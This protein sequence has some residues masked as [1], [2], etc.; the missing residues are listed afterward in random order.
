MPH[1]ASLAV[2]AF[3]GIAATSTP[4]SAQQGCIAPPRLRS[5]HMSLYQTSALGEWY[6]AHKQLQC[7]LDVLRHGAETY[8]EA[9]PIHYAYGLALMGSSGRA[10][11]ALAELQEAVRLDPQFDGAFLALGM[12]AHDHGDRVE[13]LKQWQRAAELNPGSV[14]ALDWIAKARMEAGQYTG[15]MDLLATA[16]ED[17]DLAVDFL[18]AASK[19]SLQGKGVAAAERALGSHPGWKRLRMALATV[20]VQQNRYEDAL[21]LLRTTMQDGPTSTDLNLLNLRVLLLTGDTEAARPIAERLLH[22]EP[23]SFDALYLGGLLDRQTGEFDEALPLLQQATKLQPTHF[24]AA[25]NLGVVYAKLHRTEDAKRELLY[26][27][28]LPEAGAE[29][30]FHLAAVLR[31][32]G[33]ASGA[34]AER[35]RYQQQL[36]ARAQHDEIVSLSAQAAQKLQAGD[37]RGA[38]EIERT[39]L[40]KAPDQAVHWYDLALALE[41]VGDTEG[42]TTALEHAVQL[43]SEFAV[44]WNRLGYLRARAGDMKG[45]EAAFE[46]AIKTAPQYA[47]AENNMGS[48]LVGTGRDQDA[49]VY[50]RAALAANPRLFDAW[51]NLAASLA[52]IGRL[53]EARGAAQSALGLQPGNPEVQRLLAMLNSSSAASGPH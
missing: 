31:T 40:G 13:A 23:D 48:V 42:A 12:L 36:A 18:V 45:A 8:P 53:H 38:A 52:A 21:A 2:A 10:A 4:V 14:T 29:V 3:F 43:R 50:F 15:A 33:D 30:H 35:K 5:A 1:T 32:L 16:P 46:A 24:D 49:Q 7:A 39:I 34:E 37:G 19:A 51:V 25:F 9:A 28:T 26:A 27:A 44:A 6:T 17:E 41:Q 47:E 22:Q 11:T 20:L